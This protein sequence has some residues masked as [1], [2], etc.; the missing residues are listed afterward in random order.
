[1]L[2]IKILETVPERNKE[3]LRVNQVANFCFRAMMSL[4]GVVLNMI[5]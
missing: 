4:L 5:D 1:M 3:D 2:D